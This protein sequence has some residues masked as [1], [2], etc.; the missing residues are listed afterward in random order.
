MLKSAYRGA[1]LAAVALPLLA[2]CAAAP[3]AQPTEASASSLPARSTSTATGA[4]V[5]P[6][7]ASL[8]SPTM[9][10]SA[11]ATAR[12]TSSS[13]ASSIVGCA[14]GHTGVPADARTTQVNDVDGDGKS[15]TAFFTAS[16]PYV[17]GFKTSAGG[18]YTTPDRH[19]PT[20]K[21]HAWA[22]N[23]DGFPGH[24]IAIDDGLTAALLTF[25]HCSF[26][27]LTAAEG[28]P[29]QVPIGA[30]SASGNATTGVACNNQNGGI[31]IEAAQARLL[32]NGRYNIAWS[33]L[34]PT[35]TATGA[36]FGKFAVRYKNLAA[37]DSRVHQARTSTCW[38]ATTLTV[39]H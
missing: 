32:S 20:G 9:K 34:E 10:A 35:G 27:S 29:L 14:N 22:V 38:A 2:G 11:R 16:K 37:T 8:I 18:V 39:T 17:F 12:A 3:A 36:T 24:A 25:Q 4:T 33:T 13:N 30:R 31:L 19:T 26:R 6:S 21:H 15:D 28:T 23:T 5:D 7:P 1:L